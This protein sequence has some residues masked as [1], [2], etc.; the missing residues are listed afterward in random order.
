MH[1][2]PAWA[3]AL[4]TAERT[5]LSTVLAGLEADGLTVQTEAQSVGE[6]SDADQHPADS[7]SET[8]EREK[9]LTLAADVAAELAEVAAAF[10]RVRLGAY[11]VCEVCG[12]PIDPARLEAAPATRCCLRDQER[13]ELTLGRA[14]V[15]TVSPP[16]HELLPEDTPGSEEVD[17]A[18]E[19][20]AMT[21]RSERELS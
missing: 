15:S 6:L 19:D 3:I 8:F 17:L 5:R 9:E 21:V 4:L 11:G 12:A 18:P 20:A 1:V 13:R 16:P 2:D 7:A 10:E 14:V